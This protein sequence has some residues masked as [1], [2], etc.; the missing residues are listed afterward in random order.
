[1]L[2]NGIDKLGTIGGQSAKHGRAQ[3][4]ETPQLR[5]MAG[6][7]ADFAYTDDDGQQWLIRIDR[8]NALIEGTGF[9]L[10]SEDDKDL[11][12]LPR[13]V[14]PRFVSFRHLTRPTKRRIYCANTDADI[15]R[16]NKTAIEL[17]DYQDNSVQTFV[18]MSRTAEKAK[19]R[20]NLTDTYLNDNP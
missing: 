18:A 19:Y 10:L 1:M 17:V 11:S 13:N 9:T 8:S 7:I 14:K 4:H 15:W 16:G 12:F 6:S 5:P 3:K 20:A 2:I